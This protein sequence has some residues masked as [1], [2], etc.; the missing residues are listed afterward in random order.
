MAWSSEVNDLE[1]VRLIHDDPEQGFTLLL[2][3]YGGRIQ[4]YLRQRFPTLDE[5][6]RTDA[7][8]DAMLAL[9]D[10]F[11]AQRGTLPAWFLLLAHQQAVRLLRSSPSVDWG[12]ASDGHLEGLSHGGDPLA[13]METRER[14]CEVRH[15]IAALPALE[16]AVLEA[17]LAEGRTTVARVLAK[18][19]R[20]TE[21]SIYAARKRARS[22]LISHCSWIRDWL[23]NGNAGHES[24]R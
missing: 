5:A 16:R 12:D 14:V 17:D 20:T 24:S 22:K 11:D 10:S 13:E 1:I 9:A 3:Q 23:R 15:A 7:V 18:Q 6:D 8:T 19:L 2:Q 4:G 21:G